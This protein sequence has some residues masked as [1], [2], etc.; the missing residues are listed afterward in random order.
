MT[1]GEVKR[2]QIK[3]VKSCNARLAKNGVEGLAFGLGSDAEDIL[4]LYP[5]AELVR[6]ATALPRA[7]SSTL[8]RAISRLS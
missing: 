3:E 2:G 4:L 6:D 5:Q 8:V 7:F 1:D